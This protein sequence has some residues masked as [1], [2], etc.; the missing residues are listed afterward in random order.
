[1]RKPPDEGGVDF[2]CY[3]DKPKYFSR[4]SCKKLSAHFFIIFV[5]QEIKLIAEVCFLHLCQIQ[6]VDLKTLPTAS[7]VGIGAWLPVNP[8]KNSTHEEVHFPV[9]EFAGAVAAPG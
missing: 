1:M 4:M 9:T 5:L 7:G 2:G 3:H 8:K 6:Q